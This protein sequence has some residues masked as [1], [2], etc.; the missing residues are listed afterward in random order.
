MR[1]DIVGIADDWEGLYVDGVLV[2]QG[3]RIDRDDI[4]AQ[5]PTVEY[6]EHEA[7]AAEYDECPAL[8]ADVQLDAP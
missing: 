1:I 5:V 4:M 8:L 7:W 2:T 3:H 6:R